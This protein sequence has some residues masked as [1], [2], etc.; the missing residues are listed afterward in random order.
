LSI[1]R[2]TSSDVFSRTTGKRRMLGLERQIDRCMEHQN[3]RAVTVVL[4][5]GEED[6]R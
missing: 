2:A 4:F 6:D 5:F 1:H 3:Y